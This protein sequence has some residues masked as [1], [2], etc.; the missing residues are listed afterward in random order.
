MKKVSL[1]FA[2]FVVGVS[3]VF[4]QITTIDFETEGDGYTSSATEGSGYTDVFN[5]S[6]PDVGGNSTYLWAVENISLSDPSL[7]LDQIDVTGATDFTFSV[8]LLAHHYNDWDNSDELLITYSIDGGASQNLMWVQ[9]TGEQYND[10]A[11]LDTDFD[12]DGECASVLPALTTGTGTDGCA[13]L[14][15]TFETFT[16][17]TIAL[18]GNTTLD[19]V[20]QFNGL[21][22]SDEGIYLDDIVITLAGGGGNSVP[23]ISDITISPTNPTSA[24]AVSVSADI[25]DSDGTITSATLFWGTDGSTF[26]N[27][28][29]MST[30]KRATYTTDSDIPAQS[31]GATVYYKIEAVDDEPDTTITSTRNYFLPYELSIYEIQGQ[32]SDSPYDGDEVITTGIVTAIYSDSYVIQD[33]AGAWNGIWINNYEAPAELAIGDDITIRGDVTEYNQWSDGDNTFITDATVTI[34]S[35]GNELPESTVITTVNVPTEDYEGVLVTVSSAICTNPD[36]G[37]G[38]WE[39]DDGTGACRVD[40]LAYTFYATQGT[41]Y[42][43]TGP[44][45]YSYSNFKIEPRDSTDV[46]TLGDTDSPE[47]LTVLAPND[48]TVQITFSEYVDETT[49][50]DIANYSIVSRS[51]TVDN[52]VRN[53]PDSTQV[54]LTVSGM[55]EGDYTLTIINV[56]DVNGNAITSESMNFSYTAPPETGD[57]VINEIGEP[58]DMPNTWESSYVELYNTTDNAINISGWIVHSILASRGT[59]S[60]TFPEGTTIAAYGYIIATRERASFL[61]DYGT[62]VDEAIV[63]TASATTGSG[64]YIKNGYYFSLETNT[65]IT[66][67]STSSTVYWNSEVYER[68]YADSAANNDNNWYLTYQSDPVQGTPG[69]VNSEAPVATPYTI[70]ELQTVDHSGE[71]VQT[72]GI[73]TGVFANYSQ[74]FTMQDGTGEYSGIWVDGSGVTR[75][76][77]VTVEGIVNELYDLTKITTITE[78]TINSSG[79]AVPDPTIITTADVSTENYEGVFVQVVN[80]ECTNPDLGY[81]EWEIDDGSG[82]CRVDDEGFVFIATLASSYDVTGAV[83]YA[84]GNFKIEPRDVNDID[85]VIPLPVHNI[86]QGINY[87]TIQE[88]VSAATSGD[89]ITVDAGT[90]NESMLIDKSLNIQGAGSDVTFVTVGV[91]ISGEFDGLTIE[92]LYLSGDGPG[93]KNSVIDSRNTTG[94]VSDITLRNCVIDGEGDGKYAFYGH[95]ITGTW[96]FDGCEIKNIA[97]WY[98]IDNTGSSHTVPYKLSNVVFT[99]NV[100]HHVGGS[101]AF[102]GK[103]EDPMDSATISGN[104]MYDLCGSSCGGWIWA[105]IEVN[106]ASQVDIFNNDIRDAYSEGGGNGHAIQA[107]SMTPWELNVHDNTFTNNAGGIWILTYDS[108][109]GEI[110]DALGLQHETPSGSINDNDLS[111]N[112]MFGVAVNDSKDGGGPMDGD[113]LYAEI[114]GDA[115]PVDATHNWWGS[116]DGPSDGYN[117]NVTVVPWYEDAEMTTLYTPPIHNV[118]Q[119]TYY[120]TIQ[121]AIDAAVDGDEITVDA[122]TYIEQLEITKALTLLGTDATIQAPAEM[123][124]YNIV[125]WSGSS[126]DILSVVGVHD[127]TGGDV[128]ITGFTVDGDS[129]GTGYFHGIHYFNA[130]GSIT[131]NTITNILDP[132]NPGGQGVASVVVTHSVG[133]TFTI[134]ISGNNIPEFQKGGIIIMGPGCTCTV[135]NN[136]IVNAHSGYNAGNGIQ[137]SYGATGSTSGNDVQGVGYLGEVWSATGILLF[138]SGNVSMDGDLVDNCQTGIS[139]DAWGWIYTHP[140]VV[141]ITLNNIELHSNA[142]PFVGHLAGA[143]CDLNLAIDTLNCHD[144]TGD[145]VD[146]YGDGEDPWGGGYYAGWENG[147]LTVSITNSVIE[148]ITGWDGIWTA[149]YSKGGNNVAFDV[150]ETSFINCASSAVNHGFTQ[151]MDATQC[152]WNDAN[153]PTIGTRSDAQRPIASM[154]KPF[155]VDVPETRLQMTNVVAS[156]RTG[157]IIYGPV[158][159]IPWYEDAAMTTLNWGALD[160]P[161]NVV[162]SIAG[163]NVTITWDAVVGATSYTVYSSNNPYDGFVEN[164][165]GTFDGTSWNTT[166]GEESGAKKFYKVTASN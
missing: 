140:E 56:E 79:N 98:V 142:W 52:A 158:D 27:N 90:Y 34:N 14:S 159:Y 126:K 131:N 18:S 128:N 88:A 65:G 60:F 63:P 47:I 135:N 45:G 141:D 104:T 46:V 59:S 75:G 94:P 49:S 43:V 103:F 105:G 19:I 2:L 117:I 77:E 26:P 145:G 67:E 96:T 55:T 51:V 161:T 123:T 151:T 6:N 115:G 4:A 36:L 33:G 99:N 9:N 17:S 124:T 32:L 139:Y 143:D 39:V 100:V 85:E 91:V 149:D 35:S 107:W 42:D 71:M 16:T 150:H 29:N 108:S 13:V 138:E 116:A 48:T 22:S 57:V 112:S 157:E 28:I 7:T 144:N 114:T 125:Q 37:Y 73:V 118:T 122:G 70:Y 136:V 162:I 54:T 82:S 23:S 111:G 129:I 166:I 80:A 61:A 81:G 5:R 25:T 68:A 64:V 62:Y 133:E 146:I 109:A 101:I 113:S 127:V 147:D 121:A 78:L 12:G 156:S 24:D 102:R 163:S 148:N 155:G 160:T 97:S 8:D 72:T 130:S 30:S 38:E 137:I 69:A 110:G 15:N 95:Y 84:Y 11:A 89:T 20:L 154:V 58:Y 31:A 66:L 119:D 87:A 134:D 50:E 10:P 120:E 41:P 164:T 74:M 3:L 93:P 83:Y 92:G 165:T 44:V 40:D 1:L 86:T 153:G 132:A 21:T 106:N 152:Y 76:D 53:D